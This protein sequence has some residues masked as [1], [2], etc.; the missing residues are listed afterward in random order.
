MEAMTEMLKSHPQKPSRHADLIAQVIQA[1][2]ECAQVSVGCADACLAE[3]SVANLRDCIRLNLNC[4]DI[5]TATGKLVARQTR[6]DAKLWQAML[7]ACIQ[8]CRSAAAECAK[9]QDKHEHCRICREVCERCA[10]LCQQALSAYPEGG[11]E[12]RH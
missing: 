10:D 2:Y 5:C 8:A 11:A 7:N 6:P 12:A 4:A 3:E 1:C 9:H